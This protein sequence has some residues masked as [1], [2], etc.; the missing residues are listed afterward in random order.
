M[1]IQPKEFAPLRRRVAFGPGAVI[2]LF[3]RRVQ[4]GSRRT[5][6]TG[7][8]VTAE[9]DVELAGGVALGS[10]RRE[11]ERVGARGDGDRVDV[12]RHQAVARVA[13]LATRGVFGQESQAGVVV[14][15]VTQRASGESWSA[16]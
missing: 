9:A 7:V 2:Q 6:F 5:G 10:A 13:Q 15:M 12:V 11:R 4:G 1:E 16:A 3:L 8:A 14:F